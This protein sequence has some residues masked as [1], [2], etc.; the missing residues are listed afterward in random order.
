[1]ALA[2]CLAAHMEGVCGGPHDLIFPGVFQYYDAVRRVWDATCEAA[3]ILGATPHDARHTFDVH[4]IMSGVPLVGVQKLMGHSTPHMTLRYMQHS[5][6]AFLAD[7]AALISASMTAPVDEK[8][9]GI[10]L[11]LA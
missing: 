4:A 11:N 5:P 9:D 8:A 2:G 3:G 10:S 7:D 1:V 6:Q